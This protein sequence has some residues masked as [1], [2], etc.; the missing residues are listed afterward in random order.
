MPNKSSKKVSFRKSRKRVHRRTPEPVQRYKLRERLHPVSQNRQL[1]TPI[2][3][4]HKAK[5][6]G[7]QHG[8][9]TAFGHFFEHE[10]GTPFVP[11]RKI[12]GRPVDK[13][14]AEPAPTDRR[15]H[16]QETP[17]AIGAVGC[18]RFHELMLGV[19]GKQLSKCNL[20][21]ITI[22]CDSSVFTRLWTS[23]RSRKGL[24]S[25]Q[26]RSRGLSPAVVFPH[27][28]EVVGKQLVSL[29]VGLYLKRHRG[30]YETDISLA[31]GPG[32]EDIFQRSAV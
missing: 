6:D 11:H 21:K 30:I 3:F 14:T 7:I 4:N 26:K 8:T 23:A 27:R 32:K 15:G 18:V 13:E 16:Y 17:V 19:S 24:Q 31:A 22:D 20:S 5:R 28:D 12:H 29:W 2:V 10:R 25:A 1:D 9:D